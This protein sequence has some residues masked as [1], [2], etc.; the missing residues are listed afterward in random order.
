MTHFPRLSKR[1][2]PDGIFIGPQ[3][4]E[5]L[6]APPAY[7]DVFVEFTEMD[8]TAALNWLLIEGLDILIF[9]AVIED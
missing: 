9:S 8:V 2:D 5:A 3:D 1:I 7:P 6:Y 4:H